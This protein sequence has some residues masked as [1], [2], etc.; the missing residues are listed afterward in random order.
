MNIINLPFVLYDADISFQS[1]LLLPDERSS[2]Y[3]IDD[4]LDHS[5]PIVRQS[6]KTKKKRHPFNIAHR[7]RE[8]Q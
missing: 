7:E 1:S 8:L 6:K 5:Q 3:D 2:N 4:T